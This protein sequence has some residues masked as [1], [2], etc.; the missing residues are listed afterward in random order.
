ML[1]FAHCSP[2]LGVI[3]LNVSWEAGG[4][5]GSAGVDEAVGGGGG[6]NPPAGGGGGGGVV[7]PDGEAGVAGIAG[8]VVVP[9][10]P[11]G[12]AGVAGMA[13]ITP[14]GVLVLVEGVEGGPSVKEWRWPGSF[15][16]LEGLLGLE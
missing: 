5:G 16:C 3:T 1:P 9:V 11:R 10:C 4:G 8:T 15:E 12:W 2:P 7:V 6:N 13:G 14:D